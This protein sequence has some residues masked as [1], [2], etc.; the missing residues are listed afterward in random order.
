LPLEECCQNCSQKCLCTTQYAS[1]TCFSL[2]RPQKFDASCRLL[3]AESVRRRPRM[4]L[5]TQSEDGGK[6]DKLTDEGKC[7]QIRHFE[8][9]YSTHASHTRTTMACRSHMPGAIG[10][11]RPRIELINAY[12]SS[13]TIRYANDEVTVNPAWGLTKTGAPRKR[14]PQACLSVYTIAHNSLLD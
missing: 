10:S 2:T 13:I 9:C 8:A 5:D 14:L 6:F 7:F 3:D 1:S 4:I 11:L 12:V